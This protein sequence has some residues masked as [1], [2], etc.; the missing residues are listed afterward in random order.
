MKILV[1]LDYSENAEA[2]LAQALEFATAMKASVTLLHVFSLI[3]ELEA[4][5]PDMSNGSVETSGIE[6]SKVTQLEFE[7]WRRFA[8]SSEQRL[9]HY[10]TPFLEN[11]IEA[12]T[13]H[14][15][16]Q[17]GPVICAR[18]KQ[19]KADIIMMGCRS[20]SSQADRALGS[21]SNFVIHHA[22]CSVWVIQD[23]VDES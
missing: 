1:A 22:P 11:N 2:L 20:Q 14:I 18:A 19:L 6:T 7:S 3:S 4:G 5:Q 21:V 9:S 12:Q 10:V 17:A 23:K 8:Q 15:M 16:G 13:L